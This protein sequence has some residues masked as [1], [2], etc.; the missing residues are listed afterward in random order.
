MSVTTASEMAVWNLPESP[1]VDLKKKQVG[2]G[3]FSFFKIAD[4]SLE[5]FWGFRQIQNLDATKN[6]TICR[7]LCSQFLAERFAKPVDRRR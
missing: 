4:F 2:S 7:N 3:V 5:G 6:P 1:E